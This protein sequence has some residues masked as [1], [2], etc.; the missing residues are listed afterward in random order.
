MRTPRTGPRRL[1]G[2]ASPSITRRRGQPDTPIERLVE[3]RSQE[4]SVPQSGPVS[5]QTPGPNV[6]VWAGACWG[7]DRPFRLPADRPTS[8]VWRWIQDSGV[9]LVVDEV[10]FQQDESDFVGYVRAK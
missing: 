8:A 1:P 9:L 5:R 2:V 4:G 10:V 6:A 7:A 3:A